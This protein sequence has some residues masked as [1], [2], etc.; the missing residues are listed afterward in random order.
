LESNPLKTKEIKNENN[1]KAA[2][3]KN[4][5]LILSFAF[6]CSYIKNNKNTT[7]NTSQYC[8]LLPIKGSSGTFMTGSNII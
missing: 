1:K 8:I 6:M 5:T 2:G 7:N 4:G 3:S